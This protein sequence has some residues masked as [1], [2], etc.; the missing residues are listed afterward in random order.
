[1]PSEGLERDKHIVVEIK[2]HIYFSWKPWQREDVMDLFY[3]GKRPKGK[4]DK[5]EPAGVE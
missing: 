3:Q 5:S 4:L 1:M 2:R